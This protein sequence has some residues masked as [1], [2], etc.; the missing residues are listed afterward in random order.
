MITNPET[1]PSLARA[2]LRTIIL[3]W[4]GWAVVL[5][6]YQ[7]FA[8]ARLPLARPDRATSFSA[9]ETDPSRHQGRPYLAGSFLNSHVAWDSE[10]YLSIA[11][12]GYD[13]P[14]MRAVS[15]ASTPADPK[16]GLQAAHP[17]WIS[18]NYAFFPVYP[19]AMRTLSGPLRLFGL[20]PLAAATLA[21]VL[22]SLLGTLGAVVALGD[23]AEEDAADDG[24]RAGFYLLIWP[25]SVFLA[26]VYSEGL[27]LGR[28]ICRSR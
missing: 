16:S 17:T 19:Y 25:G 22:I 12:H 15:P 7:A 11:L 18:V 3:I 1:S 27:F 23:L 14:Q 28:P 5:L 10:Y 24:V 8:P 21:G 2:R 6:A 20:D 26:Q 4:L 13:D 9:D